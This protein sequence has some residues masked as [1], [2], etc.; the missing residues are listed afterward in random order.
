MNLR[1][2]CM[3]HGDV[4]VHGTYA[5]GAQSR[6]GEG[7]GECEV[8]HVQHCSTVLG[9]VGLQRMYLAAHQHIM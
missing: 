1:E 4:T 2:E 5:P 8:G 9:A 7:E 3:Q 6:G